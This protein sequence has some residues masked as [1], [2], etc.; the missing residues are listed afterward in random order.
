MMMKFFLALVFSFLTGSLC[1]AQQEE[2]T[3]QEIKP[4]RVA[5]VAPIY[6]D[7][8][9]RYGIVKNDLPRYMTAGLEFVQG[10]EIALDTIATYGREV[11]VHIIDSKG[12]TRPAE[13]KVYYP[14]LKAMNLIIGGVRTPE[15]N[16]LADFA[17]E[18][19]IPFVSAIYPNDGGI[20]D[21]SLLIIMNST[22]K[23]TIE[24]IFSFVAQQHGM[25]Q[26]LILKQRGDDRIDDFFREANR[27]RGSLLRFRSVAVDSID[28][29]Q[30]ALLIDTLRPAV[31]IGASLDEDFAINIADACYPYR[32]NI[33]FIGMPNWTGFKDLFDRKRYQDF[34]I[35]YPTPHLSD[36]GNVYMA[37]LDNTYFTQYRK[38]A[39]DP[40]ER[41]FESAWYF[42]NLLLKYG[43][44]LMLHLNDNEFATLHH[45]NFQPS[46]M[47]PARLTDYIENKHII[48]AQI[49]N[50]FISRWDSDSGL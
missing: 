12:L 29:T 11:E 23:T 15:Y 46:T 44:S 49:L 13:W 16:G 7:S 43:D 33:T 38:K 6:I 32:H 3:L 21:D 14:E 50:G 42:T 22:L 4:I 20:R 28:S 10:A 19:S 48:I 2:D 1:F 37:Y 45:F 17:K 5:V 30:L 9:F 36:S 41:G 34:P 25:D 18:F 24:G 40:A 26:L 31:V 35:L 8:A 47:N 27:S 39:G